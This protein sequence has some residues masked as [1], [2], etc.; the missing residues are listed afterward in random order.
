MTC[1]TTPSFTSAIIKMATASIDVCRVAAIESG[2]LETKFYKRSQGL[3]SK[4][5]TGL[6]VEIDSKP[7]GSS[8]P[9]L[10]ASDASSLKDPMTA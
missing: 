9:I 1:R 8:K 2:A 7:N 4:P 3:M 10:Q 5:A 6:F